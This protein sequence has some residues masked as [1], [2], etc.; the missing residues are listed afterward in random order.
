M[1]LSELTSKITITIESEGV[2][3]SYSTTRIPLTKSDALEWFEFQV[4]TAL[5]YSSKEA[6]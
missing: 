1:R 5:G 6:E 3:D 4:L 2:V